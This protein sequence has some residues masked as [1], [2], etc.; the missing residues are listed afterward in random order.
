MSVCALSRGQ[1]SVTP[2]TVAH[3]APRSIGF[4]QQEHCSGLPFPTPGGLPNSGIEP[5]SLE[6]PA[7]RGGFSTTKPPGKP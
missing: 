7:L 6:T 3:Q 2:R 5:R 1:F 4:S